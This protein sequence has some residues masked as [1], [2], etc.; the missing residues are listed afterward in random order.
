M[1]RLIFLSLGL[2][3]T[4]MSWAQ[5]KVADYRVVCKDGSVAYFSGEDT[6]M[7]FDSEGAVL[8]I[9]GQ[10]SNKAV[11]SYA[12]DGIEAIEFAEGGTYDEQ[13]SYDGAQVD[14][15]ID[16]ADDTSYSEVKDQVITNEDDDDYGDFFENCPVM[17]NVKVV[18]GDGIVTVT[19]TS[20]KVVTGG[21]PGG[22]LPGVMVKVSGMHV[23]VS[24]TKKDIVYTLEGSSENGS[25]KIMDMG[26][27]NKR[28]QIVLNGLSLTNPQGP[29]INI[30]SGKTVLVK[31]ADGSINKLAD[32]ASYTPTGEDQK[33]AFFS[34]GQL[35]FSGTTGSLE[36]KSVGGHG[37]VS[38]DY[39]RVRGG[40][41]TV[42]SVRD[43]INTNDRFIQS[44]GTVTV[45][46]QE[47]GLDIG[48][49]YIEINAGKLTVNSGDEG[50]TASY[51]GD[52]AGN[53]DPLITP[54]IAIKGGLVKVTTTGEKGHA[55]RAMSTITM[56]GGIVQATTKGAGSKAL[57][58]EGNMTLTGGRIT[59]FTEGAALYEA[60]IKELSSSAAIRSK[61]VLTIE[62]MT[63]GV[64]STG[65]G[66]KAINN[67]GNIV[68][69][70]SQV[71]AV[72][73]GSTYQS[74]GLDSRS[75]GVTTD[76]N[77]TLSGGALKVRSYDDP[78]QVD[79]ALS[80]ENAAVYTA[81]KVGK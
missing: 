73:S 68:I 53:I 13:Y 45:D 31:L 11:I 56:T 44:G 79:G 71:T 67:V 66:A 5:V 74:N 23:L 7:E 78:L 33:G 80:F 58:S 36:V 28:S 24:S 59:A 10:G 72:A 19:G 64:K 51:E 34:E 55:L 4:M 38:D 29:A 15:A 20:G 9:N 12:V 46:A 35:I 2:A 62:N 75:R 22:V 16:A 27:D 32:G 50:I 63:V 26:E 43:G 77:M 14:V 61:G 47:D 1:K 8:Y 39:I 70:N 81:F 6:A 21:K 60:D 18:Y 25:F 76:G 3:M 17:G 37:I 54:Y 40:N 52:D 69:R 48:K 41:I 65:E 30:Q 49:G 57:M 42:N